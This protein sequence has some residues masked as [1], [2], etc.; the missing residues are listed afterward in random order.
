MYEI[1]LCDDEEKELDMVEDFMAKYQNKNQVM[2]YRIERFLSARALLKRITEEKYI[3]DL[4]LLDICMPDKDGIK[5]AEEMRKM[6]INTPI[7]FLT[8]SKEYALEAY[9]VD[10]IQYLLKPLNQERFFHVM[11][12]AFGQIRKIKD[13]RILIKI[14]G[15]I[16]Q[17]QPDEIV[18]CESQ[19]N[20]QI[21]Y[22][23]TDKLKIRMT[24]GK[25]WEILEGF[26]QF[27][28][29][30]RSYILNM[31]HVISIEREELILN[32]GSVIYLPRNKLAEFKK[33]YFIYHFNNIENNIH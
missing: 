1:A 22:L 14:S 25:L 12:F 20:Y 9:G 15:G 10:A 21:L 16:R 28:R 31:N 23:R 18:Y 8:S 19:K 30:G 2:T 17:I 4:L 32:D 26:P 6:G 7:I 27:T 5:A 29:C 11:D 13:S 24:N 3:P 33:S